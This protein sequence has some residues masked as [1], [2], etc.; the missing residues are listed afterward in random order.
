VAT[1]AGLTLAGHANRMRVAGLVPARTTSDKAINEQNAAAINPER[2][3]HMKLAKLVPALVVVGLY[4][5]ACGGSDGAGVTLGKKIAFLLPDSQAARYDSKDLPIFEAKVKSMCS[6]C[7]VDYGN[8]HGDA[9]AQL[10]QAEAAL[11]GGANVLVLDPVDAVAASAIV[12]KAKARQVPVISYD[13]LVLNA[14]AV[15]YFVSFDDAAVGPL[16][17]NGLLSVLKGKTNP[18]VVMINGDQG[19]SM[20]KLLKL[21]AQNTL[22]SKVNIAKAYDTPQAGPDTA[23]SEMADALTALKNKVDAVYAAD[24]TSA[25][26]AIAALVAAGVKPLPPVTGAGAD[27]KAVQRILAGEQYMTAYKA[28]RTEAESAAQLAYDLA[29]GVAIPASMTD[30]KTVDNGGATVPAVLVSPV[31]VTRQT[32]VSTVVA[33]GFWTKADLCVGQYAAA[34]AASGVS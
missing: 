31:S 33:D 1:A 12:A 21:G 7:T 29:Y 25:G 15:A 24:D 3:V 13:R 9:S 20:A 18:T 26:G 27:L 19:N 22:Q 32:V 11:A 16:L 28:I 10:T 17:A 2:Q 4:L 8:A 30:G 6:D 34:C 5:T 23:Q 14:P